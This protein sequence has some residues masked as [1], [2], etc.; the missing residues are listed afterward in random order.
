M[1]NLF[2]GPHP[3]E[4]CFTG[5]DEAVVSATV[6]EWTPGEPDGDVCVLVVGDSVTHVDLTMQIMKCVAACTHVPVTFTFLSRREAEKELVTPGSPLA[7][8][9]HIGRHLAGS[10]LAALVLNPAPY[11][12]ELVKLRAHEISRSWVDRIRIPWKVDSSGRWLALLL[13]G[14]AGAALMHHR[15]GRL[16]DARDDMPTQRGLR[17]LAR[18]IGD[19]DAQQ[20]ASLIVELRSHEDADCSDWAEE[21]HRLVEIMLVI[22]SDPD[23]PGCT[24]G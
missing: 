3:L 17:R 22:A 6:F 21:V 15:K 7:E 13:E 18:H 19:A 1:S 20:V 5:T 2:A 14:S 12:P 11:D 24:L 4:V 16:T 8:V 23:A 10:P 9:R